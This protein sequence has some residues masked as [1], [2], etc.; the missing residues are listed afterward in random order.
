MC[1]LDS[2]VA[3]YYAIGFVDGIEKKFL[4]FMKISQIY[5]DLMKNVFSTLNKLIKPSHSFLLDSA[6]WS[7]STGKCGT[8]ISLSAIDAKEFLSISSLVR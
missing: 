1:N 5:L 7:K 2:L 3:R 4:N 6:S 8:S